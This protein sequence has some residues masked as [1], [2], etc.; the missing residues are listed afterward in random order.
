MNVSAPHIP[1]WFRCR[2]KR[3][4]RRLTLRY[5][6]PRSPGVEGVPAHLYPRGVWDITHR[7]PSGRLHPVAV[8]SL[9]DDRG[10]YAPPGMDTLNLIRQAM[11]HRRKNQMEKMEQAFERAMEEARAAHAV[12]SKERLKAA[13]AKFCSLHL[14]RQWNNRVS[15]SRKTT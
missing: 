2:L 12:K 13:I 1:S 3:I 5:Y 6:P 7:L 8:W 14:D 9:A 4:D 15:L 10:N 11:Y